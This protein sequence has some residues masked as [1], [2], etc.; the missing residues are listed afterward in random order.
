MKVVAKIKRGVRR[1]R[2]VD[3]VLISNLVFLSLFIMQF[4]YI[5][6]NY[7]NYPLLIY[8]CQQA[9]NGQKMILYDSI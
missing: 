2:T 8:A 9:H 7:N 1:S 4:S 6:S 5:N 3:N